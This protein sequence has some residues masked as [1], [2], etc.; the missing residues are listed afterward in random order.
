M[1]FDPCNA[2]LSSLIIPDKGKN[3]N[4]HPIS[5]LTADGSEK[6]GIFSINLKSFRLVHILQ[7]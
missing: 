6:S 7:M 1:K 3:L 4:L 5:Q 2:A